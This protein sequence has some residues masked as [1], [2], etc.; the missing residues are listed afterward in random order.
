M[1][2]FS[3]F[4]LP[5]LAAICVFS[6]GCAVFEDLEKK[7][8]NAREKRANAA[9]QR[10]AL[11]EYSAWRDLGGRKKSIYLNKALLEKATSGNV[12]VEISKKE[13]RGHLLVRGAVAMDFP[14]STGKASHPTPAVSYTVR[15]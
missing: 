13:Q 1:F 5:A 6:S 15:A 12:S 9:L 2:S 10:S 8:T 4:A 3:G 11:I 14:V 7:Q